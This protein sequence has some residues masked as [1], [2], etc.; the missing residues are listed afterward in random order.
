LQQLTHVFLE[1]LPTE[2]MKAVEAIQSTMVYL[3]MDLTH[4]RSVQKKFNQIQ[5]YGSQVNI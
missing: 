1:G 5:V 3:N 2:I 4:K